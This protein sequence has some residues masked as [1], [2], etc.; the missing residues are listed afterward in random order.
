MSFKCLTE[1]N[2]VIICR[3]ASIGFFKSVCKKKLD[4]SIITK[5][6]LYLWHKICNLFELLCI[7]KKIEISLVC[8]DGV[9]GRKKLC[10]PIVCM[11]NIACKM[12]IICP[13]I[14]V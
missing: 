5:F 14:V 12:V 9:I 6:F 10:I 7:G 1:Y 11:R 4:I 8:V 13:K 2:N 3:V